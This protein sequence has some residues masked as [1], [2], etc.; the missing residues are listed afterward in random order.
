VPHIDPAWIALIG[1]LCGGAGLKLL[2]H[3]L[4][5]S[6]VKI[7]EATKLR[8]ELRV[9]ITA[10]REETKELEKETDQWRQKYYNLRDEY[11]TMKTQYT[12]ELQ[13]LKDEAEK[14]AKKID[15]TIEPPPSV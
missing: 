8:D 1:T 11:T 2:E 12:I 15:P 13:H 10:L 14:A 7:D 9:E 6:K 4:S 5:R 3:W